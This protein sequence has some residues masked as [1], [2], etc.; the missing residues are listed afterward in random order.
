MI[1]ERLNLGRDSWVIEVAA[2]DGYLLR[3]FI[4]V[5]I[6]CLG[7]EPTAGTAAAAEALGIPILRKFFSRALAERLVAEGRQADLIIGN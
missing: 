6:P 3:N 4:A 1:R 7:I 5:K 2:N